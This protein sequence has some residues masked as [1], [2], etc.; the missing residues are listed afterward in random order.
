MAGPEEVS[1]A[2][3]RAAPGYARSAPLAELAGSARA[4]PG[5]SARLA[6]S[7]HTGRTSL[8]HHSR[9]VD[10]D[11]NVAVTGVVAAVLGDLG[12]G[13]VDD[14]DL[15]DPEHVGVA[16]VGDRHAEEVGGRLAGEDLRQT[17]VGHRHGRI[18]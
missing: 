6:S 17:R 4:T 18:L 1:C 14:A 13:G 11:R 16:R 10:E 3:V 9:S 7:R 2:S 12:A 8:L 5:S 15:D